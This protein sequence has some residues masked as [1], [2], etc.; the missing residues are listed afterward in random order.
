MRRWFLIGLLGLTV[1]LP[2]CH[3]DPVGDDENMPGLSIA[4]DFPLR[5][6]SVKAGLEATDN[7]NAIHSLSIWVFR[8]DDHSPVGSMHLT[9]EA[10]FPVGG[11]VKRYTLGVSWDFINNHPDVDIFVLANAASIG[12]TLG[13]DA[14]Y[15]NLTSAVFGYEEGGSDYFGTTT[16]TGSVGSNGLPMSSMATHMTVYG[17]SP[18][19]KVDAVTLKRAV[20]R[21]R[22][23][24]CKTK[25][26]GEEQ[27]DVV[28]NSITFYKQQIPKK[29]YV[30]SEGATH[31]LLDQPDYADN[32]MPDPFSYSGPAELK[33]HEVPEH[34]IYVNQDPAAYQDMLNQAI[35]EGTLSDLGYTYLRETDERMIGR[36]DYTVNGKARFREFSTPARG[37]FARN[38]TWTLY[39]YFM[40]GRNVQLS[41]VALPWDKSDYLVDFSAQAITVI[42]K[43]TVEPTSA[44]ITY[45]DGFYDVTLIP[46][47]AV[48]A[49]LAITTPVGGTLMIYPQGAATLFTV[50]P[51]QAFINPDL[52]GG[53]I[54]IEIRNNTSI[55]VNLSELSAAETTLTLSF[56]VEAAGREMDANTEAIDNKYRFHL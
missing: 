10:D 26:D 30:F 4:V 12:C 39:A 13:A 51:E 48:K 32:F 53:R 34:L 25:T 31:I 47:V 52:N 17:T 23:V 55:D 14:T 56:S 46:G 7:E 36:I 16:L 38:H 8:S 43:F 1:L 35:Q 19:L 2:A 45:N 37:D 9:N 20:S 50:S 3:R 5:R 11:G 28:I 27:D 24:L 41:L 44:D 54:D 22:I 29:E 18:R 40:S 15:E 49:H 21:L 42:S 33:E 6:A